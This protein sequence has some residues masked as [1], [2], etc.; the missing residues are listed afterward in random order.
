MLNDY[1]LS[2]FPISASAEHADGSFV[3]NVKPIEIKGEDVGIKPEIEKDSLHGKF[4]LMNGNIYRVI[5][6]EPPVSDLLK[7]SEKINTE[8]KNAGNNL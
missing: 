2:I 7:L 4:R 3:V 8:E 6:E 5:N 1:M